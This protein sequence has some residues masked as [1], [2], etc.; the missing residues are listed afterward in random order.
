MEERFVEAE[1]D[2]MFNA[3]DSNVKAHTKD[4]KVTFFILKN[5]EMESR[6]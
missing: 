1:K 5:I 3:L 4:W 2:D 6:R